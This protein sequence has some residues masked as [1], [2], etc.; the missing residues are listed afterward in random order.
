MPVEVAQAQATAPALKAYTAQLSSALGQ[1]RQQLAD[2][3]KEPE[4]DIKA[5][6]SWRCSYQELM[7]F[8]ENVL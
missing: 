4:A 2:G 1:K 3:T 6:Q 5:V 8:E 7:S